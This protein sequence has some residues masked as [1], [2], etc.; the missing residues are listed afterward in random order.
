MFT[1]RNPLLDSDERLTLENVSFPSSD[2]AIFTSLT[3]FYSTKVSRLFVIYLF[4]QVDVLAAI[5]LMWTCY[6]HPYTHKGQPQHL[7]LHAL[8][9]SNS[10]WIL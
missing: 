9:F 8:L 6:T 1:T 2:G 10:V 3:S 7:E 5:Q 4:E